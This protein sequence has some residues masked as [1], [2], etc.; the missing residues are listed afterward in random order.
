VTTPSGSGYQVTPADISGASS[1]CAST[2]AS[3]DD[4]LTNLMGYVVDL[5]AVW[6][7]IASD[8]FSA[9]MTDYRVYAQ[10]LHGALTDIGLGLQGNYVNYTQ[11]EEANIAGLQTVN[12]ELPG[13][14][15]A[16]FS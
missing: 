3:I 8:T 6:R 9:L 15:Y 12:G 2:A 14:G 7:G 1:S 5:E 4:Q 13:T 16:N 11:A 10:M